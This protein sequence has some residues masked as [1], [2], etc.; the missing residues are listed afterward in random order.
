MRTKLRL[1]AIALAMFAPAAFATTF[2]IDNVNAA[3]IGFNDATVVAPVGGNTGTTLGQQRLIVFQQAA[4]QWAR[5][6]NSNVTIKV[7][8][9]MV[10]QTCTATSA[11]LG[12][13]G[14]IS[15]A[16]AFPGTPRTLTSYNIAEANALAGIDLDPV[17]DD[18]RAMFNVSL[19]AGDPNCLGGEKWWYG[20]D[21]S[22]AAAANTIPLLPVVF[23]ELGH[24]LGFTSG[25]QTSITPGA[26]F[27]PAD[28]PVW[29]DYLFD[30]QA[31]TL[32]KPMSNAQRLASMTNDPHLVWTGPRTN[33]QA[34]GYLK[35]GNA[36]VINSP[37][38]IAGAQ[39]VGFAQFGPQPPPMASPAI[40]CWSTTAPGPRQ[41]RA[42]QSPMA[43][44][45]PARSR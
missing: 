15:T 19:D 11:T 18:I 31:G 8:A 5:L 33:K 22:V 34:G 21:P 43:P 32:L 2:T 6:L 44:P 36:L 4:N 13:A 27:T 45:W 7:Q 9:S 23:H 42:R 17:N 40:W 24:G 30:T 39:E 35:A 14:A 41:T 26:Y 28:P 25:I 10:A 16:A 37:A 12:S 1:I 20:I 29:A 3:G 38:G